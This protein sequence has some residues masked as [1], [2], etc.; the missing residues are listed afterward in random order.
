M[1][2]TAA[3]LDQAM[4]LSPQQREDLAIQILLSIEEGSKRALSKQEFESM[5][6]DRIKR[7][8]GE[9]IETVDAFEALEQIRQRLRRR[10]A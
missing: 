5:L 10:S 9:E 1:A 2:D 4:D 7:V 8:E 3:L 6:T